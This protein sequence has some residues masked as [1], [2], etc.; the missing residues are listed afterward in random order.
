MIRSP[1]VKIQS[2]I[3]L[4]SLPD[5]HILRVPFWHFRIQPLRVPLWHFRIQPGMRLASLPDCNIL[6]VP[7]GIVLIDIIYTYIIIQMA[8]DGTAIR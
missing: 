5:W 3:R 8:G 4:A 1:N 2:N 6:T 7:C